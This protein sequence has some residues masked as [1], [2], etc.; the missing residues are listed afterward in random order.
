[1]V[2]PAPE[3]SSAARRSVPRPLRAICE[4]AMAADPKARYQSVQEMT[5]DLAHYL[6]GA[7]VSAYPEH[8]LERAGR[9]YVRHRTAVVLV[10]VYL[11][12]RLLFILWAR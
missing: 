11:L 8:L 2:A 5:T 4:K 1:M 12:M 9:L 6:D 7:P 3:A 10:A